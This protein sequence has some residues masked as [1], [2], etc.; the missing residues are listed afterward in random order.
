M[1]INTIKKH[2]AKTAKLL[3]SFKWYISVYALFYYMFMIEYFNPPAA[4][5]PIYKHE[6][7]KGN[8]NY[9]DRDVYIESLKEGNIIILL[10]FFIGT[11]NMRNHPLLAKAIFLSPLFALVA[12]L[13]VG[14][15]E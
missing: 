7:L 1:L 8:W 11:S 9:I 3:W 15:L 5:D 2:I 4:N 10:F 12:G 13:I 14:M 6:Y